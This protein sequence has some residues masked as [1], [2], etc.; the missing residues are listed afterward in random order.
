MNDNYI[1]DDESYD[2]LAA[3][4]VPWQDAQYVIRH[5]TPVIRRHLG[6]VLLL[7]GRTGDGSWLTIVA[8]ETRD[9]TYHVHDARRLDAEESAAADAAIGGV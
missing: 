8:V 1:W 2:R 7:T 9:D 6:R 5:A 4:H 3:S